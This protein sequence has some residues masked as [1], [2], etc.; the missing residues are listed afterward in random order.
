MNEKKHRIAPILLLAVLFGGAWAVGSLLDI[1][2]SL[3]PSMGMCAVL[4]VEIG[5]LWYFRAV[6]NRSITVKAA[7]GAVFLIVLMFVVFIGLICAVPYLIASVTG[8]RL[9]TSFPWYTGFAFAF[10]ITGPILLITGITWIVLHLRE[11]KRNI[12]DI[13]LLMQL[14]LVG[15]ALFAAIWTGLRIRHILVYPDSY[16]YPWHATFLYTFLYF[17][18]WMILEGCALYLLLHFEKKLTPEEL[19]ETSATAPAPAKAVLRWDIALQD[20]SVILLPLVVGAALILC[21]WESGYHWWNIPMVICSV[22]NVCLL[23]GLSAWVL[24]LSQGGA[25]IFRVRTVT[26][27]LTGLTLAA[28]LIWGVWYHTNCMD[29]LGAYTD[30]LVYTLG[31]GF[32]G[33][34]LLGEIIMM[35]LLDRISNR[36]GEEKPATEK[37]LH[38]LVLPMIALVLVGQLSGMEYRD[39]LPVTVTKVTNHS[40][41]DG[42]TMDHLTLTFA[43]DYDV[44]G[45]YDWNEEERDGSIFFRPG[46]R[47]TPFQFIGSRTVGYNLY[48]DENVQSIYVYEPGAGYKLTAVRNE[49]TGE[50]EFCE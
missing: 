10:L 25:A 21:L 50:W 31:I 43:A 44:A 33:P 9:G 15:T 36:I 30:N 12:K 4:L 16:G 34:V 39:E 41:D 32:F 35:V 47:W 42:R 40:Y 26:R 46:T 37:H 5:I 8:D 7:V 17:G 19:A 45:I 29:P 38:W 23:I 48:P 14:L 28:S 18:I 1:S 20:G 3:S 27:V 24:Y 6:R 11:R 13:R 2:L 49:F 22:L